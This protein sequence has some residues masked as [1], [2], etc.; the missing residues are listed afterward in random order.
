MVNAP[1]LVL[2][3]GYEAHDVC[4]TRRAIIL[5]LCGKAELV[6][7][8]RGE[9]HT[10]STSYAIPSVIRLTLGVRRPTHERRLTRV[11][12]FARDGFTCQYC[13]RHTK[14][15]TLDH[16]V[17][18]SQGGGHNWLNVVSA[19]K[20][21]N[22]KKGG[23]TPAEAGMKLLSEIRTPHGYGY[24]VPDHYLCAREEWQ[25]YLPHQLRITPGFQLAGLLPE[26]SL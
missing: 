3:Q 13:G 5:V 15:L 26:E 14:D 18:R 23:R 7:D 12:V 2:N 24:H 17:P 16:V 11:E 20:N 25:K 22:R 19:C 10:V 21:C 1:V 4:R 6:E 9:I 8:S